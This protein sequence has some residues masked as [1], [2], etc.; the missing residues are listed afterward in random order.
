M[1]DEP[2]RGRLDGAIAAGTFPVSHSGSPRPALRVSWLLVLAIVT[3]LLIPFRKDIEQAHV[4]LVYLLVVLGGSA[5]GGRVFGLGLACVGF[6]LID[7]Y[8][9]PPFDTITVDK[10]LDWIVLLAFLATS[11]VATQL[12]ARAAAQA[13]LAEER[14]RE[15]DRFASLGAETL[16]VGRAEDALRAIANVI[17]DTVRVSA[18]EIII[19]GETVG[20]ARSTVLTPSGI[21][22]G[23][24]SRLLDIPLTVRG[25]DV[26]TLRL[27][28]DTRI[29]L[30][31]TQRR[32]LSAL[33]YYAALAVERE[34]LAGQAE[35]AA[36][37]RQANELKDALLSAVSHD[38]R[39]PLTIIKA[40][41]RRI[42]DRGVEEAVVI[43]SQADRLNRLVADLLD[44][45]RLNSSALR[46][47]PEVA[48]AEDLVGAVI[49]EAA[50]L[51]G[52][53]RVVPII[54]RDQPLLLGY[55][56]LAQS[57]RILSNLIENASK[58]SPVT[59][60]IELRV[61]RDGENLIFSVSDRGPGVAES[62]REQVFEPFHRGMHASPDVGGAGLGL[63]IARRLA[64]AQGGSLT[65]TSRVGGGSVF[66][67]R[68]PA[69]DPVPA[70]G[71]E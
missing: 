67:L 60:P 32:S 20:G 58:Y 17:R 12:L 30:D 28:H 14:A 21:A 9:Q 56:D 16:N 38:L 34:R 10:G 65:Y 6:L 57:L 1:N 26:G 11:V 69:A 47:F 52:P 27:V 5:S 3:T 71:D 19:H 25:H 53:G 59:S 7:Y 40:L 41:A 29:E 13:R 2:D 24:E 23:F 36:A 63:A 39:T 8:F 64:E 22:E 31:E 48:V 55:F 35:H 49:R 4:V 62:E 66:S 15:I 68:V 46:L 42:A 61:V 50:V 43:E 51:V 37:L 44:M 45:S 54:E 70:V 33:S 18:C